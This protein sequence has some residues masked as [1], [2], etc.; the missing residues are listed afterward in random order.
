V[1]DREGILGGYTIL[2]RLGTG[3][4]AT[5]Y[6]ARR[7]E[8]EVAL[9]VLH[10]H[11]ARDEVVRA[12]FIR[13]VAL[14]RRLAHP[15]IVR[16]Y[17]VVSWEG[18]PA[19]AMELCSGGSLAGWRSA[20]PEELVRVATDVASALAAAH[21]QGIVHRD[22]KPQNILR[23]AGGR[24]KVCDFGSAGV[25]DS[26]GL[27]S[28]SL[29]MGTPQ[30]VGPEVF[31]GHPPDPRT[32]LYALGA[33]LFEAATGAAP[34]PGG[35]Q[36]VSFHPGPVD[37]RAL[38]AVLPAWLAALVLSLLGPVD[39]RPPD[40]R[41]VL[42]ALRASE[43]V[44][45]VALKLCLFCGIAIPKGAPLCLHCG[46]A[47]LALSPPAAGEGW[48][49]AL[50]KVSEEART[51]ERLTGL[52]RA[53]SGEPE[54]G[55]DLIIGDPRMYSRQEQKRKTRIPV[56]V[57]DE[58]ERGDAERLAGIL[59]GLGVR[60]TAHPMR[61]AR[62]VKRGPL[63]RARAGAVVVPESLDILRRGAGSVSGLPDP[64]MRSLAATLLFA[65]YDLEARASA[66]EL[67][68]TLRP[69]CLALREKAEQA[70]QD[71][72]EARS[73]VRGVDR[74]ALY[75]EVARAGLERRGGITDEG[76][77]ESRGRQA[78]EALARHEAAEL[79]Q[80]RLVAGM[81]AAPED[82]QD[83]EDLRRALAELEGE[84][85]A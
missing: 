73:Y 53:V 36:A 40:A 81:L 15:C 47:E 45:P 55:L 84:P 5:V 43:A 18:A 46:E 56:R 27:T 9:K 77:R 85:G 13:E 22:L 72:A 70:I 82:R 31:A 48:F 61:G 67:W 58:L 62:R 60:A 4:T 79:A 7:G 74:G 11:L 41:S 39:R 49:V 52:L 69:S 16:V 64:W 63:V 19:L 38:E 80:S 32:D 12:R 65:I 1:S 51:L 10:P 26:V 2:E 25:Q 14:A 42:R 37:A 6:R 35:L 54:F 68:E 21:E 33:I 83:R 29:L 76:D 34:R 44:P 75:A 8:E 30:Y 57:V 24:F 78:L 28:S 17:D 23:G 20:D 50:R 71:L 66:H 59:G 3:G